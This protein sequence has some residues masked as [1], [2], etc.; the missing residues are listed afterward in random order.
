MH[1]ATY[2]PPASLDALRQR[3]L[4]VGVVGLVAAAAG[5][6]VA[7]IR[8]LQRSQHAAADRLSAEA[9]A[10]LDAADKR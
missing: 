8:A 4:I 5:A 2:T 10:A 1:D 6:I 9:R 7:Y 3:S